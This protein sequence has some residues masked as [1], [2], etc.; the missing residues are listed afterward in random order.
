MP[1]PLLPLVF[2][3]PLV[4]CLPALPAERF[5]TCTLGETG[6]KRVDITR[7]D[8]WEGSAVYH[9]VL[10]GKAEYLYDEREEPEDDPAERSRGWFVEA[11]CAGHGEQVLVLTGE[12]HSNFLQSVVL[13][14]N[15]TWGTWERLNLAERDAPEWLYLGPGGFHVVVPNPGRN[16]TPER[17]LVY[18]FDSSKGAAYQVYLSEGPQGTDTL[19]VLPGYDA[20]RLKPRRPQP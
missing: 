4:C 7:S 6:K 10:E 2:L 20:I 5:I 14:Y 11:Q 18:R 8:S 15:Q 16:E 19:P 9:L 3:L 1:K 17:Y 12:F 13:R